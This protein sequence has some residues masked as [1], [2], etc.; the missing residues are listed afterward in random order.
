MADLPAATELRRRC[1]PTLIFLAFACLGPA[2]TFAGPPEAPPKRYE[3]A[4]AALDAFIAREVVQKKIPSLSIALVDDQ[5]I[6]WSRGYGFSDIAGKVPATADTVY[7]VGSVSKLFTDV[8][9]MQLVEQGKIDLDAPVTKYLPDFAPKGPATETITLRRMMAHRSGLVRESPVGHYF[10]PTSPTLEATVSSLNGTALVYPP[11]TRLKYSNAAIAAVGL[12]LSK[13]EGMPFVPLVADRVLKP[14]GMS[15]SGFAPTPELARDLAAST[16]WTYH[17]REFRSPTFELGTSPAGCMYTTVIDLGRFMKALFAGGNGA[18]GSILRP[19]TLAEMWKVQFAGRPEDTRGFGLG[20]SIGE[21]NGHRRIGHGGAIYGFATELSALPDEKLGVVVIAARDCAN[22]LTSRIAGLSL[23]QMLAAREDK[24]L[25]AIETTTPL[26]SGLAKRLA[27]HYR[28]SGGRTFDLLE[29]Q[30]RLWMERGEGGERVEL[31]S[32][33]DDL[34]GDDLLVGFSPR[35]IPEGGKLRLGDTIF[36]RVADGLPPAP[37]EAFNGLIGEYGWDHNVLYILE[38]EGRLHALIEWFFLYPLTQEEPDI[39]AFPDAGLYQGEKLIFRR[40]SSGRA[41]AVEAASVSFKRRSIDGENGKTF[42]I[43]PVR[44]AAEIRL[45]TAEMKPPSEPEKPRKA[46]LVDLIAVVPGLKLDIRYATTNNFLSTPLYTSARALMQRP[47]AEALARVQAGL[48][49][50]G[51][52]LLIHDAY[53]PWRVTKLF[54]EATPPAQHIFVADPAKG[55]KHNRGCAVDLTLCDLANEQPIE[56][57]GGYDEFSDRSFP[58]YPGG[59]SR[60]RW[61]RD[62]LRNAMEAEGFNVIDTEWWH[63]DYKIWNDYPIIDI[64]FEDLPPA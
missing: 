59:T 6:V 14:L 4:V 58:G 56:M 29:L 12:A 32:S 21:F 35:I 51:Y 27:G 18:N 9:V 39:Y 19:E 34:V 26:A 20:F 31:R 33:G 37:P 41:T 5:A 53:R 60:Q 23:G 49:P 57:T 48:A 47:A 3:A 46:D 52:G 36:E 64:P 22:G 44:S 25:P 10:D 17:G 43:T 11:G 63:F 13:V 15:R 2:R 38:K 61:H 8:A 1:R 62:L 40:D 45:E 54:R 7:R 24:P 42:R 16:M 55:S 28:A 50:K 30:G